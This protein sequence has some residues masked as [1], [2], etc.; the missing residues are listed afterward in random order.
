MY[1]LKKVLALLVK[2]AVVGIPAQALTIDKILLE[3]NIQDPNNIQ[4]VD[5][6]SKVMDGQMFSFDMNT[7]FPTYFPLKGV[8]TGFIFIDENA[9]FGSLTK[10]L[11]VSET[12]P[13]QMVNA[14][15]DIFAHWDH[16]AGDV[17]QLIKVEGLLTTSLANPDAVASVKYF[18]TLSPF[19]T[20]APA[21]PVQGNVV[22]GV[23]S[24]NG[25]LVV[26]GL[27]PV[28]MPLPKGTIKYQDILAVG[29]L[30]GPN[31]GPGD[32]A[33]SN[34]IGTASEMSVLTPVVTPE[35]STIVLLTFGSVG[36]LAFGRRQSRSVRPSGPP[37]QE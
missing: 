1:A 27:G 25:F 30:L 21:Q 15:L 10:G 11:E 2:I 34:F 22:T 29:A 36:L 19:L 5:L 13:G 3:T 20:D 32:L 37:C 31:A 6:T 12:V 8:G 33:S 35:P 14:E 24:P 28:T 18:D 7:Y 17:E 16:D 26:D 4:L 9:S 23:A